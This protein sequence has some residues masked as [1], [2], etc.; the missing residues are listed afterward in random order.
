MNKYLPSYTGCLLCGDKERNPFTLGLK[1]SVTSD[2]VETKIKIPFHFQGYE[3]VVHGGMTSALLD[4]TIGWAVTVSRK[5]Y[6]VTAELNV[7][8]IRPML[9]DTDI[10]VKAR[11]LEHKRHFSLGEGEIIDSQGKLIAKGKGKFFLIDPKRS[12][13][14]DNYL[15]YDDDDLRFLNEPN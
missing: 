15:K 14:I 2:G 12:Q 3:G 11:S 4:E 7:R 10:I 6:F 1:F 5:R 8:Y 13:E 9:V